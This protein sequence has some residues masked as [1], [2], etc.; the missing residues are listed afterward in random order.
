MLA[1]SATARCGE[2]VGGGK[3]TKKKEKKEKPRRRQQQEQQMKVRVAGWK[4]RKAGL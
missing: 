4:L 3:T 2:A 1:T